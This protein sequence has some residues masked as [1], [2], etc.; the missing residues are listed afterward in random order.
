MGANVVTNTFFTRFNT[1]EK[2]IIFELWKW[3]GLNRNKSIFKKHSF[4]NPR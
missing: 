2:L 3:L 4:E 1:L